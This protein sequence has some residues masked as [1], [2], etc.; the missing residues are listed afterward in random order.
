M[1]FAFA[2]F[3]D[4]DDSRTSSSRPI[5]LPVVAAL[6][7]CLAMIVPS[8]VLAPAAVAAQTGTMTNEI[9]DP[10]NLLGSNVSTVTDKIKQ[11]EE[12]TGVHVHL[13]YVESFGS[14]ITPSTWANRVLEA[15]K[16]EPNTVLLAVA[17]GDGNL[18]VAVS[19]NSDEWLRDENTVDELSKAA[20]APLAKQNDQN[21]SGAAIAMMDEIEQQ[22]RTSTNSRAIRIG[23]IVMGVVLIVL[24]IVIV[25]TLTVRRRRR[26]RRA[27]GGS[28]SRPSKK[29]D[30][31]SESQTA[32]GAG[33]EPAAEEKA[34]ADL[35][36]AIE[37]D[38][39]NEESGGARPM[40][41]RQMRE[42][43]KTKRGPFGR[44]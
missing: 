40:T 35:L 26:G 24:V 8:M 20:T 42:A 4:H 17:S 1:T 3:A 13:Q 28:G 21:W 27:A 12:T 14:D 16:P 15:S 39:R 18:I 22:K 37:K 31:S 25:V 30:K 6:L 23:V 7:M 5:M 11:T 9:T 10:Q 19:S 38:E 44:K 41:R 2:R 33:A 36:N 29:S 34:M 43:R 32:T